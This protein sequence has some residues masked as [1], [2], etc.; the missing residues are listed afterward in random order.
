MTKLLDIEVSRLEEVQMIIA[1]LKSELKYMDLN[2]DLQSSTKLRYIETTNILNKYRLERNF[3]EL[4]EEDDEDVLQ[5]GD[6][7]RRVFVFPPRADAEGADDFVAAA[8]G[9]TDRAAV[10]TKHIVATKA[11]ARCN[12]AVDV[13]RLDVRIAMRGNRV[14]SLI[15]SKEEQNIGPVGSLKRAQDNHQA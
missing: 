10:S 6:L 11:E 15:V 12:K 4:E 5:G 13:R 8:N 2:E 1:H 3:L 9:H 14:G 7:C